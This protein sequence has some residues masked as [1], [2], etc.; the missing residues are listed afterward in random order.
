MEFQ[1]IESAVTAVRRW[2]RMETEVPHHF[3]EVQNQLYSNKS[4]STV[5]N[6]QWWTSS[7]TWAGNVQVTAQVQILIHCVQVASYLSVTSV[8]VWQQRGFQPCLHVVL[9]GPCVAAQSAQIV[10]EY[11]LLS[12]FGCVLLHLCCWPDVSPLIDR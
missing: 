5:A 10:Y 1:F 3:Y 7:T 2:T 11:L 6:M 8:Q 4:R 9:K 12:S